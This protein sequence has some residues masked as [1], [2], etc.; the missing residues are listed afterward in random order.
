MWDQ[1][2]KQKN[3]SAFSLIEVMIAVLIAT[4]VG[5]A[6]V[7]MVSNNMRATASTSRLAD[8][9]M[10]RDNI[11]T[12]LD[13]RATV[14]GWPIPA[15]PTIPAS[16]SSSSYV[17]RRNDGSVIPNTQGIWQLRGVCD[18]NELMIFVQSTAP[19]PLTGIRYGV[20]RPIDLYSGTSD[21]CRPMFSSAPVCPAGTSQTGWAGSV[22]VCGGYCW[23]KNCVTIY[24]G[25]PY[26]YQDLTLAHSHSSS[27]STGS[28]SLHNHSCWTSITS[29][30]LANRTDYP[31]FDNARVNKQWFVNCTT[32][33]TWHTDIK[34]TCQSYCSSMVGSPVSNATPSD[35]TNDSDPNPNLWECYFSGFNNG[36]T[37]IWT[38]SQ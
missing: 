13:C 17:L 16:C 19:D 6:A 25:V 11:R 1:M 10:V 30:G 24:T 26:T 34:S 32:V 37:S 27:C 29:S 18:S 4:F 7:K 3:C 31:R 8:L 28:T 22:P 12:S 23:L 2:Y 14:L 36:E 33:G 9:N 21:L 38:L 15:N 35:R 5:A 20:D